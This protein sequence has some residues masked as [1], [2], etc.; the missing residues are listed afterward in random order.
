[1]RLFY[2]IFKHRDPELVGTPDKKYFDAIQFLFFFSGAT[3]IW[4]IGNS[5]VKAPGI[6]PAGMTLCPIQCL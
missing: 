6:T 3:M 5:A 2:V 1:M 4:R